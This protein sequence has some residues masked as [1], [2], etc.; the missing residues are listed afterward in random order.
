MTRYVR[1]RYQLL[2]RLSHKHILDPFFWFVYVLYLLLKKNTCGQVLCKSGPVEFASYFHYC[3]S[4]T[5]DQR[6]DY[7]FVKR[8]FR[9]LFTRQGYEFD[10][11]FDWT[12]LKYKQGQKQKRSPGAPA[13]PIQE[14]VQKQAGNRA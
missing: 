4:L 6:P 13:R 2:S 3:H 14:D 10:Y 5:F 1:K 7:A 11:I 8:L 12:V 9:D